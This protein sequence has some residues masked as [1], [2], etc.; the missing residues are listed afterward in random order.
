M[1]RPWKKCDWYTRK[2]VRT[3]VFL[4]K[5]NQEAL[6]GLPG[7]RNLWSWRS[8]NWKTPS[9]LLGYSVTHAKQAA[10]GRTLVLLNKGWQDFSPFWDDTFKLMTYTP[11]MK[12]ENKV[13]PLKN[14]LIYLLLQIPFFL[15]IVSSLFSKL[16]ALS[17][18][19]SKIKTADS[20]MLQRKAANCV[21][22]WGIM[23]NFVFL[24]IITVII[25]TAKSLFHVKFAHRGWQQWFAESC[26][27]CCASSTI[28]M[29]HNDQP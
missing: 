14:P 26:L 16:K 7:C 10:G 2:N 13:G 21:C 15:M 19:T 25:A 8:R 4:F 9:Y 5:V 6:S 23:N 11:H 22:V 29:W 27:Y 18:I 12:G 24:V 1:T 17:V 20:A 3:R 28:P